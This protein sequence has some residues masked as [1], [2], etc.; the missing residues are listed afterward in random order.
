[1]APEA[2]P[3]PP[4]RRV[5]TALLAGA[6]LLLLAANEGARA[7]QLMYTCRYKEHT[8][9]GSLPPPEC[10]DQ[11]LRELNPDGTLHRLIPAPLTPEQRRARDAAE[12]QRLL[13]EEQENAQRHQDRS[14][15]ET[16]GSVS[17]IE[18]ARDR[19]VAARQVLVKRAD[20]RIAQYARERKKLDDEAEFYVKREKPAKLR[21]AY[22]ANKALTE[23]QEKTKADV[24]AEIANLQ[25][26]YETQIKR[27][28]ELEQMAVEA[29][30]L[31]A[32]ESGGAPPPDNN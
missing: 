25:A 12:K 23:Q 9:T 21:D 22:A 3:T 7:Q 13:L 30:A 29:A 24:L 14:L 16:Y 5:P 6:C 17:E 32:R 8:Y 4:R 2:L 19:A 31:R 11:D 1:M 10:K 28:R 15:L 18:A 27:Y 26:R 20:E